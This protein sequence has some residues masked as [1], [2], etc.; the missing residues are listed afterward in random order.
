MKTGIRMKENR[1]D[2]E[3]LLKRIQEEER[4]ELR[5]KLKIYLGAAPGVGKTHSMLEDALAKRSEG[6]DIAIGIVE[7][8]GRREIESLVTQFEMIPKQSIEYHGQTLQEFD[9]DAVIKRNPAIVLIDEMA[10][11]NIPGLRHA[12]RWQDIKEIL[13]RGIDVYT[14]LN[15]QHIESLNDVVSQIIHTR[16]KETVPDSML[17]QA[18]SLELIDIPPEDLL[19]RLKEGKVYFPAQA[20][21]AKDHFFQKGNLTALREIALR[22][23]AEHVGKQV[24]SYR[25][26][27]GIKYIWPT[28][29]KLLVCISQKAS[30][31]KLIRVAS[32]LAN[33]LNAEWIAIYV[34]SPRLQLSEEERNNAIQHLRLAEKLGAETHIL[35][36]TNIIK[37]IMTFAHEQNVTEIVI[38]KHIRPR[39]K[40]IFIRS[41]ADD[42]LRNSGEIDVYVVTNEHTDKPPIKKT[43][44]TSVF[45]VKIYFIMLAL[46]AAATGIASFLTPYL[47]PINLFMI[48]VLATT[49]VSLSGYLIPSI[50]AAIVSAILF[51]L[52]FIPP[53][54][55]IDI[56]DWEYLFSLFGLLFIS[57][58]IS[59]L[60]FLNRRQTQAARLREN[61]TTALHSL[62]R[63]LAST[64][65]VD[66]LL[67]IAVNNIAD[68]FNSEVMALLPYKHQLVIRAKHSSET[69]L[70]DKELS[71]AAWVYDL[72][73]VAGLGTDT[74]P[75]SP[76]IY[77]P[78]LAS[79]GTIGVLRV[80]PLKNKQLFSPQQMHLLEACANQVALAIEVDRLHVQTQQSEFLSETEQVRNKLLQSVSHSLRTPLTAA[81]GATSTLLEMENQLDKNHIHKLAN[82]IYFELDQLNRLINNL[83]QISYL[84]AESAKLNK[85]F[86]SLKDIIETVATPLKKLR[87][88][89]WNIPDNLPLVPIDETLIKEV[90]NHLIENA[91][92]FTPED[93]SIEIFVAL[94]NDKIVIRIEDQGPGIVPDE[95]NRLFEKFY[96]GRLLT[97]KRGLGLGLAISRIIINAHGG[98]IRAENRPEGGAVFY[99]T[100]P[101]KL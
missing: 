5:G 17:K 50:L 43:S 15:V 55:Q 87:K 12:K 56:M 40:E 23:T 28:K 62:S 18:S 69:L 32:R 52:L 39:W 85:Q 70:K 14:T 82:K 16:V 93:T 47:Q 21:I 88:I 54:Y 78:L 44:S 20:E 3:R 86:V 29:E 73:Q 71:I 101:L 94:E 8:H 6:L 77:I 33:R 7:T 10:H 80:K 30:S 61:H 58:S 13:D 75:F 74:L 4:K 59:Q 99:F 64:R 36:G 31:S 83:L 26:G 91:I 34:D 57:T 45:P 41:L 65:G 19:K 35:T 67:T 22:I 63:A 2:P 90:L 37:E 79:Q 49:A 27:L 84:E 89:K 100:L 66:K 53:Y 25:Q 9:L 60:T 95:M 11:T 51:N 72:G 46:V 97:S 1:P 48:Y 81:M 96:R 42:I 38:W 24:L 68:V 98:T 92:Q 76:A